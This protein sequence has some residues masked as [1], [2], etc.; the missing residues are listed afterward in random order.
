MLA[1]PASNDGAFADFFNPAWSAWYLPS[2]AAVE[3]SLALALLLAAGPVMLLAAV[4]VRLTSR[5]PAFY[6]QTRL[7]RHGQPYTIYKLRTMYHECEKHSGPRWSPVGDTRI[8]P[9][10]RFLRR[11]HIDELPQ[12]WNVLRRD[13][14]LIGPRPERP[15]FIPRLAAAIPLATL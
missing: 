3:I 12:L 9:L 1:K 8:T 14:S 15:E 5:G 4:L 11:T 2:K 6:S 7:G 13:M 10:G